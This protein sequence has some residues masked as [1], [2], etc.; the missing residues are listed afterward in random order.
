MGIP[1]DDDFDIH[2]T[3]PGWEYNVKDYLP[4]NEK[5]IYLYDFGDSWEHSVE[6]EGLHDKK[7]SQKYPVCIGGERACPPEDVGSI[8]G[9]YRFLEIIS[10]PT[11]E[12]HDSML[13][14]VG[15]KYD[16]EKFDSAKVKFK[17]ASKR[18]QQVFN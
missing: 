3:L 12:E 17:N 16:P 8:P 11:H 15:W 7:P 1:C 6:Y 2:N 4:I 9:Y 10:D 14:W 18:W 5:M 13:T